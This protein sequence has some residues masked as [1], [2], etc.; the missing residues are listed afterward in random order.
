MARMPELQEAWRAHFAA[1]A[2]A[3]GRATSGSA[4]AI[5][6]SFGARTRQLIARAAV[7]DREAAEVRLRAEELSRRFAT[8]ADQATAPSNI[9]TASIE[10]VTLR[11]DSGD[12][13]PVTA[14]QPSV[15]VVAR[16]VPSATEDMAKPPR[17]RVKRAA[18]PVPP[19]A[20]VRSV[21]KKP[22]PSKLPADKAGIG[23][24][25]RMATDYSGWDVFPQ[26]P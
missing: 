15:E 5:D 16:E 19:R 14:E 6:Q 24:A 13:V 11:S 4:A 1:N 26:K 17:M 21:V 18:A 8:P 22:S 20:V 23:P 3:P 2:A 9:E 7:T 25:G 12:A 10:P